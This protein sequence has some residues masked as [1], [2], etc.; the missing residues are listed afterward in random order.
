M[1]EVRVTTIDNP[2]DPFKEWDQWY[3]YDLSNGYNT[4]ERLASVSLTSDQFT[5]EEN[6]EQISEAIDQMIKIGTF[7]KKGEKIEYKKV[8]RETKQP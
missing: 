5:D 6:N 8:Y 4:C 3:F 1:K 7:N 2:Y